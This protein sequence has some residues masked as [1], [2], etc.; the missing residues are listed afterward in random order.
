[1][2]GSAEDTRIYHHE[3][4][5]K[6]GKKPKYKTKNTALYRTLDEQRKGKFMD[7][8]AKWFVGRFNND[9]EF[10]KDYKKLK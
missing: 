10:R 1:M 4:R 6:K 7:Y 2:H 5:S 8:Q 9:R 3:H